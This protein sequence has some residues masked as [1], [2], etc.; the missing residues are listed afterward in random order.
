MECRF[1]LR[2]R[3]LMEDAIVPPEQL[4]GML[5][6]LRQ[7]VDPFGELLCRV[8]QKRHCYEYLSGL[9]SCVERKNVESIAYLHDQE[10]CGLQAFI[11]ESPWDERPLIREL[12][13]QIGEMIGDPGAVLVFDPS[14]F[15]KKG[16]ES[17]G[18]Q[19][20]WCGRLGK[21][22]N[23]QVGVYLA[24]A[25]REYA[26]VDVRLYLPEEW[27]ND[28]QR[29]LKCGVPKGIKFCKR[30]ELALQML[31]EHGA[32]LPHQWIAG[33]DE[34]GRST[35]FRMRLRERGEHYVL[36]VPSNTNVRDLDVPP[37]PSTPGR[38][39][40]KAPYQQASRWAA[41]LPTGAW[42]EF[43]VREGEKGP[44]TVTAAMARV[45][46]S[47][48]RR[49]RELEETLVA[50]R[51]PQA[52]GSIKHDYYFAFGNQD[53]P[54]REFVRVAK[55]EHRVEDCLQ[56][57]K[58]QAGLADYEVRNWRGWHHHQV[59]SL[60]A[61][62]FLLLETMRA[63]KKDASNHSTSTPKHDWLTVAA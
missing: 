43:I 15:A 22:E 23:C 12:T 27:A 38:R 1:D 46:V 20:Q 30:H 39:S 37:P 25:A 5:G 45:H 7:F 9:V 32:M 44:L 34:M 53:T 60:L 50:I 21:I 18:V 41:A 49:R 54:L 29:R 55:A 40:R 24:Y 57:A 8:E 33:D 17:V 36:A 51:E 13:R 28:K 10:R 47:S 62:W 11:G 48:E 16:T 19:R 4:D 61:T 52:D 56:R 59:L 31:D 63:K 2:L 14:A 58:G 3:E 35:A 42:Q 6:R 26:L